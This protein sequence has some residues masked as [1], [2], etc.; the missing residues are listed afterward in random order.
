MKRKWTKDRMFLLARSLAV[1]GEDRY[2]ATILR[3]YE[4][5]LNV[6]K[7]ECPEPAANYHFA[8]TLDREASPCWQIELANEW[9]ALR[10]LISEKCVR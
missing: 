5:L 4:M 7:S 2:A 9:N 3:D 8:N 10:K 1:H 6:L